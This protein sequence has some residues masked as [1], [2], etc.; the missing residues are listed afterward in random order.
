MT[1]GET[2]KLTADEARNAARDVLAT[3]RLGGDP[4][5]ERR[6]SREMPTVAQLL[7]QFLADEVEPKRKRTT[8]STYRHYVRNIIVPAI[9]TTKADAL[10][11]A[12]VNRLHPKIGREHPTTANRV[13]AVL[14]TPMVSVPRIYPGSPMA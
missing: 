14:S 8:A 11:K 6:K 12:D 10:T 7:E 5:G 2:T 1:L 9:G 3:V 4:A 13:L